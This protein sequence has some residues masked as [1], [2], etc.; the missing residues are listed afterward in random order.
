M[1]LPSCTKGSGYT[2]RIDAIRATARLEEG[3][4]LSA[5]LYPADSD[6]AL[7]REFVSGKTAGT[8]WVEF[9][10]SRPVEIPASAINDRGQFHF[11]VKLNPNRLA[12][13][14]DAVF[15]GSVPLADM[16][17]TDGKD[18]AAVTIRAKND[19][20]FEVRVV[21]SRARAGAGARPVDGEE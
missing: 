15:E 7:V 2:V 4:A 6:D 13:P 10:D 8:G 14:P 1:I 18:A 17:L 3:V 20:P 19:A 21:L 12:T 5:W 11:L 16:L 9:P